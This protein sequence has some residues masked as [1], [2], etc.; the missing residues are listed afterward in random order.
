MNLTKFIYFYFLIKR[1]KLI[2]SWFP[3]R[4]A[5]FYFVLSGENKETLGSLDVSPLQYSAMLALRQS[6]VY[7]MTFQAI[8][9]NV[10]TPQNERLHTVSR[11]TPEDSLSVPLF[12]LAI[13]S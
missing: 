1:L 10:R 12:S 8:D 13:S 3:E 2:G 6:R 5:K 7:V 11:P 9:L 4:S